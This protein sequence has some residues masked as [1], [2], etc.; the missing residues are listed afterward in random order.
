MSDLGYLSSASSKSLSSLDDITAPVEVGKNFSGLKNVIISRV[1]HLLHN[2]K[3][4]KHRS[5]KHQ[6][7]RVSILSVIVLV[8]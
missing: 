6:Q 7:F 2:K 3:L 1:R 4:D 8:R 5:K